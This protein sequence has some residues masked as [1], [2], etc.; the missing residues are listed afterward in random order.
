M[1]GEAGG[2]L[3]L[4]EATEICLGLRR[5]S[6]I[7]RLVPPNKMRIYGTFRNHVSLS[8]TYRIKFK[9]IPSYLWVLIQFSE[10]KIFVPSRLSY[11]IFEFF[12]D[13]FSAARELHQRPW[14]AIGSPFLVHSVARFVT[15]C[16]RNLVQLKCTGIVNERWGGGKPRWIQWRLPGLRQQGLHSDAD[17]RFIT[18]C[19][20]YP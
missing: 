12:G 20:Y 11:L 2:H 1:D 8:F 15:I 9:K 5:S 18:E 14:V 13:N 6:S 3:N 10:G 17:I 19:Q 7:Y 16:G 4:K